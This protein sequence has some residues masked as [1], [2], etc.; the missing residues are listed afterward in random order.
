[1]LSSHLMR[2]ALVVVFLC[3]AGIASST[4]ADD[5]AA[6]TITG[7]VV[8]EAGEPAAGVEV[9]YQNTYNESALMTSN[10]EGEFEFSGLK[11]HGHVIARSADGSLIGYL[12]VG[13]LESA[14]DLDVVLKPPR[15]IDVTATFEGQTLSDATVEINVRYHTV[16]T[17]ATDAEGHCQLA[18]PR[19]GVIQ[20][21]MVFQEGLGFA[22]MQQP[23]DYA[24][25]V[26]ESP[27]RY[28]FEID[29]A[30][31]I[32]V[33]VQ[34]RERRPVGGLL[35]YPMWVQPR[36]NADSISVGDTFVETTNDDGVAEFNVFPETAQSIAFGTTGGDDYKMLAYSTWSPDSQGPVT[37]EVWPLLPVT[38]TVYN[39]DGTPAAGVE[40][41][42]I[43]QGPK[44]SPPRQ[45]SF[46][47]EEMVTD[48]DG[49][50]EFRALPD[51]ALMIGVID[52]RLAAESLT[53]VVSEDDGKLEG[54]DLHLLTGTEFH[55]TVRLGDGSPYSE[56]G[57]YVRETA[58]PVVVTSNGRPEEI[59]PY[60]S[61]RIE[62]DEEGQ[63]ST[64]LSPGRYLSS[65]SVGTWGKQGSSY[66][67]DVVD[68]PQIE[69]DFV[70]NLLLTEEFV[71]RVL[72]PVDGELEPAA[73]VTVTGYYYDSGA[74][75]RSPSVV[76]DEDGTF[77]MT[78]TPGRIMLYAM[79]ADGQWGL[80]HDID[81][82]PREQLDL[83]LGPTTSA[84][85]R[86]VDAEGPLAGFKFDYTL[87]VGR[88]VSFGRL[89]G[90]VITDETGRFTLER[91]IPGKTYRCW[92]Q[93]GNSLPPVTT[94][95]ARDELTM[96]LGQIEFDSNWRLRTPV[97][98]IDETFLSGVDSNSHLEA[99]LADAEFNRRH[100]LVIVGERDNALLPPLFRLFFEQE[101]PHFG[102]RYNQLQQRLQDFELCGMELE[103]ARRSAF[104]AIAEAG[105]SDGMTLIVLDPARQALGSLPEADFVASDGTVDE[106]A[107]HNLLDAH[108]PETIDLDA[109]L[110]A[111]LAEA[112]AAEPP[113]FMIVHE[114]DSHLGKSR[115]FSRFMAEQA[116]SLNEHF[117]Y[118]PV[119]PHRSS[120]G[121]ELLN[122]V[123]DDDFTSGGYSL[124]GCW[125]GLLTANG[126][127]LGSTMLRGLSPELSQ[128]DTDGFINLL[129]EH[130]PHISEQ[131]LG[132]WL[133]ELNAAEPYGP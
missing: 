7:R 74:G 65:C 94:F 116:L 89:G 102:D 109:L 42:M 56:E 120:R 77:K 112:A 3:L 43:A 64:R 133:D 70:V 106:S 52:P 46:Q 113:K 58:D 30:V 98:R 35:V 132:I 49:R 114:V 21:I 54:M 119:N 26:D 27:D 36:G 108:R 13:D 37:L 123:S 40:L 17:G 88:L 126:E 63:F 82:T 4:T 93:V 84:S 117:V 41:Q 100:V 96:D 103:E 19:D 23:N 61:R 69:H 105:A 38:G 62:V 53:S 124:G 51:H 110:E 107:V 101:E 14:S 2:S 66:E 11:G 129:L 29:K 130:A 80:A 85:G 125:I 39:I 47:R 72:R 34:D 92:H 81:R 104:D 50:Y 8:D 6:P 24:I 20:N 71:G 5:G 131:Q 111:A 10:R 16:A 9:E 78:W 22:G 118:L 97:E 75:A 73:G 31:R 48:E 68:Q 12:R 60:M 15:M 90:Q 115:C 95:V 99:A 44:V 45:Q 87:E 121:H 67:F 79:T 86:I 122:A 128:E 91:L 55:G 76:T 28:T 83:V 25:E 32:Q 18:I 59:E 127:F 57:V 33:R 1:M